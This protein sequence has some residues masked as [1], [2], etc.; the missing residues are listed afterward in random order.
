MPDAFAHCEA[1]VRAVDRDRFLSALFAPAAYRPALFALYA[2]N[3]EIARVRETVRDPVVGEIRLQWWSDALVGA[4]RGDAEANPVVSA[5]SATVDR[6]GLPTDMLQAVIAA[7]RFDLYDDP[8]A[9]LGELA[10]YADGASGGLIRLAAQILADGEAID[11]AEIGHHAGMAHAIS[12]LLAALPA[13]AARGQIYIPQDILQ[14]HGTGSADVSG[15]VATPALVAAL[16]DL[17]GIAR[18]HLAKGAELLDR[19][20]AGSLPALLPVALVPAMLARSA[21]AD[22]FQPGALSPWRRQW[23]IWRASRRPRRIFTG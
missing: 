5:L 15:R 9:T 7:R 4:A 10:D 11:V 17:R 14:R 12:G 22:P 19:V 8:M 3:I 18:E 1:L 13:H 20:P 21:R 16:A 6:F 23:L 2:F